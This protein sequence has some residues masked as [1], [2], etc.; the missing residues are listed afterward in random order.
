MCSSD[1]RTSAQL[2]ERF[3]AR[4]RIAAALEYNAAVLS[5]QWERIAAGAQGLKLPLNPNTAG[6]A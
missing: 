2:T 6:P 5:S 3:E 4:E 1:L